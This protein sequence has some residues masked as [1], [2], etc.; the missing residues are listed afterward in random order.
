MKLCEAYQNQYG[1]QFISAIPTNLYG[2]GDNY[3]LLEGHV[4]PALIRRLH[5]AKQNDVSELFLWGSGAPTRD[6]MHVEDAVDAFVHLMKYYSAENPVN[7]ATGE[8]VTINQL[9]YTISD[10]VGFRGKIGHDLSK[11]DGMLRRLPDIGSLFATGWR[12][13]ITLRAGLQHTYEW[14]LDAIGRGEA[15]LGTKM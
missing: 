1:A 8:E 13:R 9:A 11:P 4:V 10:I 15:R 5:D 2:P 12:P 3:S 14:F 6:F 7:V